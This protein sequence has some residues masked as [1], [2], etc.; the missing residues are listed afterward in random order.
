MSRIA[1]I[2]SEGKVGSALSPYLSKNN[3]IIP[4]D[5]PEIDALDTNRL[6]S[7]LKSADVVIHLAGKYGP[8]SEG[9]ENWRSEFRD[10]L[11]KAIF[12]SVLNASINADI[13]QFIHASS[14]HIED[15]LGFNETHPGE[16]L[17][18]QPKRFQTE[19]SSGYGKAKREQEVFVESASPYFRNGAVSVRLGGV[20]KNNEPMLQHANPVILDHERKVWLEHGDLSDLIG[21]I[22]SSHIKGYGVT[23]ATSNNEGRFH[24]LNNKYGWIPKANSTDYPTT[25]E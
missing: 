3:E 11:N 20:T 17:I 13:D 2:G 12:D 7:L 24:N 16:F 9:K 4:V 22:L 14:I 5:L 6:T 8:T 15:T 25:K 18:A 1:I 10:P 23:Y 19:I 21:R